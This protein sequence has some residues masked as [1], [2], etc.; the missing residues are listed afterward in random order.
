MGKQKKV[1]VDNVLSQV[2][3]NRLLS[4]EKGCYGEDEFDFPFGGQQ[5]SVQILSQDRQ[6]EFLLDVNSKRLELSKYTFQHRARK[7]IVLVRVD[8]L[9]SGRHI[10]PDGQVIEGPHIHRYR[11]DYGD[12]WAEALPTNFGN[13]NKPFEVF[14][15]FMNHCNIQTKP[16]FR[17]STII[18]AE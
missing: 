5:L 15:H 16:R 2:E 12:K 1:E 18:E 4:L 10:N 9:T 13:T 8:L 11:E 3:A 7:I 6:N 17:A 14:S